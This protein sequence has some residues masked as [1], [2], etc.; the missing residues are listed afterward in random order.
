MSSPDPLFVEFLRLGPG[1]DFEAFVARHPEAAERLRALRTAHEAALAHL[2]AADVAHG[3]RPPSRA[4]SLADSL[5]HESPASSELLRRL[6]DEGPKGGRYELRGEIARGGMG[7]ILKV[8]DDDL[9]RELAMKV[10]LGDDGDGANASV[11]G[12]GVDAWRIARFLE[13]AQITGQLD[14]PCVVPVH[15][16]GLDAHGRVYFTMRLVRGR[17]LGR[18][19]QLVR[20]GAEGWNETRALN[21]L[22]RV[23]EATAYAHSKGVVHRDLKPANVMVGSFGEVYVMDWGLARVVGREDLHDPHRAGSSVP[24][25]VRTA[26]RDERESGAHSP[27]F[28]M[29]GDVLGTPAYMSPEQ[30]TGRISEL[31]ARSDV[32][33][34]GAM[35]H[36]L[37]AG[38]PP[39][40]RPGE[41]PSAREVLEAVRRGPPT[42]L[43]ELRPDVAPE[44]E[45][46]CEKAMAR[47]PNERYADTLA[48][49]EDLRAF[50]EGRVVQ[51]H[52]TGAFVELQKWVR[53]NRALAL[54][55]AAAVVFLV[56]GL[57]ASLRFASLA[58]DNARTADAK[59]K[60]ATEQGELAKKNELLA[61]AN[62]RDAVAAAQRAVTARNFLTHMLENADPINALDKDVRVRTL[63]ADAARR[64]DEGEFANDPETEIVLHSCLGG[65][66]QGTNDFEEAERHYRAADEL[67]TA[68]PIADPTA[69]PRLDLDYADV[70]LS[71]G[72]HAEAEPR[73]RAVLAALTGESGDEDVLRAR[74]HQ[75]LATSRYNLGATDEAIEHARTAV[76]LREKT[77]GADGESAAIARG[78]L[79]FFLSRA[80]RFDEARVEVDRA[81]PV[82]EN[83]SPRARVRAAEAL[84]H[85]AA[86]E[87]AQRDT[88]AACADVERALEIRRALYDEDSPYVADLLCDLSL[89]E[90][91][92][93][94]ADQAESLSRRAL[95]I[96]EKHL[97]DHRDTATSLSAL[98]SIL[99]GRGD[100]VGAR[101]LLE[102]ALEM[103]KRVFPEGSA[104]I[105]DSQRRLGDLE[106]SSGNLEHAE[107]L[108]R[109]CL[110]NWLRA[111]GPDHVDL[112]DTY[113]D[114]AKTLR[115]QNRTAEARPLLERAV[116]LR[117]KS[118]GEASPSTNEARDELIL[119]LFELRDFAAVEPLARSTYELYQRT[120]RAG[121]PATAY[122][123]AQLGAA[124]A[125]L[126]KLDEAEPLLLAGWKAIGDD[127]RFW[128]V[129]KL[130]LLDH[131]VALY[132]AKGDEASAST[133]RAKAEALRK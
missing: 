130:F 105:G 43:R 39:Y 79:A 32:Y 71:R 103:R 11:D 33:S 21:V 46:I 69:R 76:L 28:T 17:D 58:A 56:V 53:R 52:A 30:A 55:G 34:I 81:L 49:A 101:D 37:L 126:G 90:T 102:R 61:R 47:E 120:L 7:A 116:A 74:A 132:V 119:V 129:N 66:F 93:G 38:A 110:D 57:F 42:P 114:L 121:H 75:Q 88:K 2:R 117:S 62:E 35:L 48:L 26:R 77:E 80:G 29:E 27:A 94:H 100:R 92:R 9:N 98:G 133:Y 15:E 95:E 44:L 24:R 23:C 91:Q 41:R 63:L 51:A 25:S 40:S 14:H 89:Y 78:K 12:G 4:S 118:L 111:L 123:G 67:L 18:V 125:G 131:L 22:L 6:L 72:K 87:S 68:H 16:L 5:E 104:A 85:R 8:W 115:A 54:A 59:A 64:L 65:A 82:L 127:P 45:S 73:L 86:I 10:V 83:G 96:R 122:T 108:F 70:L 1:A 19:F 128:A 60:E 109:A 84:R 107:E 99:L 50:L 31:S 112:A 113:V 97:G 13:E 106:R 3:S 36:E 20:T 124:L